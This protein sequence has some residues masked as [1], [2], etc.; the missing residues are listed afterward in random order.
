[1]K[2]VDGA[3]AVH[4]KVCQTCLSLHTA[5]YPDSYLGCNFCSE[6]ASL[7][8]VTGISYGLTENGWL[9]VSIITDLHSRKTARCSFRS[10]MDSHTTTRALAKAD[11]QRKGTA[12]VVVHSDPGARYTRD[13]FQ[14][15]LEDNTFVQSMSRTGDCQS[16]ASKDRT[17]STRVENEPPN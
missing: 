4:C 14:R 1:M 12:G 13:V 16:N 7:Q 6:D 11:H 10:K 9:V 5:T 15:R 2:E 8:E 17:S 3:C